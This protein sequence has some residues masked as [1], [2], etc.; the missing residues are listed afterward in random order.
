MLN[1]TEQKLKKAHRIKLLILMSLLLAPVVIS[2][3]LYFSDYRPGTVNYGELIEMEGFEGIGKNQLDNTIFRPRN[4]H[5]RW[6]MIS[7]D[8]GICNEVCEQKLYKMRQVRLV[9][10]KE[11]KRVDR[12]WLIDDDVVPNVELTKE[13]E[14]TLFVKTNDSALLDAIPP[15][16]SQRK[17]IYMVDPLGNLIMRYPEELN[18][19]KMGKDIKRLLHVSQLEH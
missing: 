13:Y 3:T 9:Q 8:S 15:K 16:E 5:G 1:E 10:N 14:G 18:P 19:T 7:V 17:H 12:L 2:Y 11:M 4:F 6:T